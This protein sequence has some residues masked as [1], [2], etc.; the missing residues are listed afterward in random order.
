MPVRHKK[1]SEGKCYVQWGNQ[2]KY[3]Y[4]C[5]SKISKE[6]AER[7][8]EK[9][10]RII[11]SR[12]GDKYSNDTCCTVD[13][14]K[15]MVVNYLE[16]ND[17]CISFEELGISEEDVYNSEYFSEVTEEDITEVFES[18]NDYPKSASENACKVLRWVEK[19]GW[20]S[21]GESTGKRRANQLC[22]NEKISRDTIARMASFKRH[23]QHKD[24]P[25]DEGC[26][27]L[28]WDSWG[29]TE[30][31]EWAIRKLKQIDNEKFGKENFKLIKLYRY[32]SNKYGSSN[33]GP[34]TRPFC[35]T[36]ALRTSAAMMTWESIVNM[37]SMNPGFGKGGGDSYSVFNYRGGKNCV[38]KWVKYLYD[39]QTNNLVKD[40]KQPTQETDSN[41]GVPGA[42]KPKKQ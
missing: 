42:P 36:L 5:D 12:I 37:N 16:E 39:P 31:V 8:S 21:C 2:K 10:G 9:Q 18:Y 41:G 33:I 35:R 20:G 7:K 23:Q 28:M 22:N 29:G 24:V 19:N 13:E 40:V 27:G 15:D 38:H 11:E 30:G 4:P 32:V 1:D 17:V 25:Y 14:H 34:N 6:N 26:G 3:Y